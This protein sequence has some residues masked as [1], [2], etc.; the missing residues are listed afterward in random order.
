MSLYAD[1]VYPRI[2][3]RFMGAFGELRAPTLAGARG[4]VLELGFGTGLN[5]PHY[6]AGVTRL[7]TV[8]PLDALRERVLAR[9]QAAPF[10]VDV[11]HLDADLRLPFDAGRFD[12][13]TVTWSLCT[14]P[15][16]VAALREARRVAKP[17]APLL[18]IEHGRSE[19]P[20]VA[21]WQDWW[22]PVQRVIACGCNV[23]RPID[24]IV[25]ASGFR[26][27]QLERFFAD[28]TPRMLGE[29]YR[30]VARA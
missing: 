7:T 15:D 19:D 23:N 30:G 4:D 11:H 2:L 3:D 13:I 18:F 1:Y 26:L 10:P 5:L 22:N 21:R 9:I 16:P 12:C 29:M 24:E 8:D 28:R 27:E 20:K 17:E 14:I 25:R 6:P